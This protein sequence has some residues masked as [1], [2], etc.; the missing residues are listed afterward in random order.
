MTSLSSLAIPF[1]KNYLLCLL[2]A[3]ELRSMAS[4]IATQLFFELSQEIFIGKLSDM[5]LDIKLRCSFSFFY[6]IY[7]NA[8]LAVLTD[9]ILNLFHWH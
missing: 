5:T 4:T 6:L 9:E 1:L 3:P 8:S 2:T 7:F